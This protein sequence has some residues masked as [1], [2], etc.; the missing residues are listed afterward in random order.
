MEIKGYWIWTGRCDVQIFI[1]FFIFLQKPNR[2]YIPGCQKAKK[3]NRDS[4]QRCTE[5]QPGSHTEHTTNT[6][7]A[8]TKTKSEPTPQNAKIYNKSPRKRRSPTKNIK[9]IYYI[10]I[11]IYVYD[12]LDPYHLSV[13]VSLEN[14]KLDEL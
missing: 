6:W 5:T 1:L 3:R 12:L 2:T 11:Y 7:C 10:Y 14:A 8:P 9:S 4:K 13:F